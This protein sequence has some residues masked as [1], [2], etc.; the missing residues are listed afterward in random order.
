M[1]KKNNVIYGLLIMWFALLNVAIFLPR[2]A[3]AQIPNAI[4]YQA[5][6]RDNQ[7]NKVENKPV[8]LQFTIHRGS[9]YGPIEYQETHHDTTNKFGLITLYLGEGMPIIGIFDNI[10]WEEGNKYLQVKLDI[11]NVGVYTDLGTTR[12][13]SVPYALYAK[14]SGTSGTQGPIGATGMTGAT[15]NTGLAGA[16]GLT[17]ATGD[18]GDTTKI[19]H[20]RDT[21]NTIATFSELYSKRTLIVD[22][23]NKADS[24][25]TFKTIAGAI[26]YV[27]I[28]GDTALQPSEYL[29]PINTFV[30]K[31]MSGVYTENVDLP[32]NTSLIGQGWEA[33]T[34]D[35][36]VTVRSASHI[37][38]LSITPTD[39][40]SIAVFAKIKGH[41]GA[42]TVQASY[43]TNVRVWNISNLNSP[44]YC[45]YNQSDISFGTELRFY[46]GFCY[47]RNS[48]AGASAKAVIA[49]NMEGS[50]SFKN[51]SFKISMPGF[52]DANSS[53]ILAWNKASADGIEVSGC[54]WTCFHD[55]KPI[56]AYNQ[57][58][59]NIYL[60]ITYLNPSYPSNPYITRG[61]NI[62]FASKTTGNLK[63]DGTLQVRN[64]PI[65]TSVD[66]LQMIENGQ[67]KS[68]AA[69]NL[70]GVAGNTAITGATKTK[71]T[72]DAKGLVTAGA[73]AT[74]ADIAASTNKNYITDAQ[75]TLIGNTSGANTGDETATTIKTKL[76]ITTLSGNN[77]GDNATNTL[78][79]ELVTNATH[80]GDV[81]GSGALT[82]A[83]K[84][85][86]TATLPISITGSPTVIASN[87]VAISI[88]PAT[89]NTAGS[90]SA[91][92]KTKL[93]GISYSLGKVG[94]GINPPNSTLQINGSFAQKIE[95][96]T[97]ATI[98]LD[99]TQS[100]VIVNGSSSST[101]TLPSAST[102]SG[103]I[104][105]VIFNLTA[106][107]VGTL[108]GTIIPSLTF[109]SGYNVYTLISDGASNWYVL[110]SYAK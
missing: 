93:D 40:D 45:V 50:I 94:I 61:N 87:P 20:F 42:G 95:T 70:G 13:V 103:R 105:T 63:V 67:V 25:H 79:S 24:V 9:L 57:G 41:T 39:N 21:L 28:H 109:R 89:T 85:T 108:S 73:N 99:D 5:V 71:I 8:T 83:N 19:V 75:Q 84:R 6:L 10:T 12:M 92:D 76:G 29:P 23:Y 78:Y 81:T 46:G 36:R 1:K 48:N 106:P 31:L 51:V 88:A 68:I 53:E 54:S 44:V 97:S 77:T 86:M 101:V 22:K 98:F 37:E 55:S 104:Y 15:G 107:A 34:I 38:D 90:M 47:A 102:R 58:S 66:S 16:T 110:S 35:G 80:T 2:Q 26:A 96:T 11:D 52:N 33:T 14:T 27:N 65:G 4:D 60:D 82:I 72:Y 18:I 43:L 30:I 7:G 17:G 74:T 59:T 56:I 91:A 69:S 32:N 62:Y 49:K 64:S 3:S 100:V